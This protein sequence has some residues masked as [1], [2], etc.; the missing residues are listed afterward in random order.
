MLTLLVPT[1]NEADCLERCL[2]SAV[3]LADEVLVVDSFST[4]RTLEIA[5]AF[6]ARILHR[7]YENS[8]SQKNW[9]IPQATHP[10]ILLLDADEWLSPE[11]REELAAWKKAP[12]PAVHGYWMYRANHFMGQ[13]IRFSG[14]Q[15]D[16]VIRL[17]QRDTCRYEPKNVHAEIIPN[18]PVSVLRHRLFHDT[19][20]GLEHHRLKLDRYAAWQAKDYHDRTGHITAYH[21][22]LKPVYRFFR[23]FILQGGILDGYPGFVVARFGAYAVRARY[24]E[25]ARWR[26][27]N[28][29]PLPP[30]KKDSSP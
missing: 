8:A 16:K 4:D 29:V 11:L 2:A 25:L 21:T 23:Q 26:K 28:D 22:L 9:A 5:R 24:R 20:K 1:F 10:W 19:Y 18:G 3:G 27:A 30:L 17:F 7:E 6:G 14:W 15:N 13:R 12:K